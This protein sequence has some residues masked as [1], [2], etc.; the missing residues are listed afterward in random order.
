MILEA[1]YKA[2]EMPD[3]ALKLVPLLTLRVHP[4]V[5]ENDIICLVA[6]SV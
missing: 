4:P 6:A 5:D 1:R 3:T 2:L